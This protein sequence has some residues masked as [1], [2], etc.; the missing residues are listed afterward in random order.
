MESSQVERGFSVVGTSLVIVLL[1]M[2]VPVLAAA[3]FY[4]ADRRREQEELELR[5]RELEAETTGSDD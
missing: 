3:P 1:G 5:S 2:L 4:V